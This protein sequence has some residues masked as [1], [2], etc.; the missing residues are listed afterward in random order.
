MRKYISERCSTEESQKTGE[1][2]TQALLLLPVA[3]VQ[4]SAGSGKGGRT[5]ERTRDKRGKNN[6]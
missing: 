1:E 3:R 5:S 4:S 2:T 6:G